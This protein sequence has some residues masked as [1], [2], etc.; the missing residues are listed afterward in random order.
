MRRQKGSQ[1][2]VLP[3]GNPHIFVPLRSHTNRSFAR[4]VWQLSQRGRRLGTPLSSPAGHRETLLQRRCQPRAG[5][6]GRGLPPIARAPPRGRLH[7]APPSGG[8]EPVQICRLAGAAGRGAARQSSPLF[9]PSP[10]AA[11]PPQRPPHRRERSSQAAP[12][13]LSI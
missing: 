2:L 12:T 7:C 5:T 13:P 1:L 3:A 10:H 11:S 8:R 4:H 6:R 9:F